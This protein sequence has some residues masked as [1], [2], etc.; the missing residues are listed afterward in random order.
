MTNMSV[1]MNNL[2]F[3]LV[4]LNKLGY[5]DKPFYIIYKIR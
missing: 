4:N 1:R 2:R 3:C 5:K